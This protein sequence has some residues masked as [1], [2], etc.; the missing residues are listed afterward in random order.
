MARVRSMVRLVTRSV[1]SASAARR[2]VTSSRRSVACWLVALCAAWAC[3]ATSRRALFDR[4][5]RGGNFE[6]RGLLASGISRL[7]CSSSASAASAAARRCRDRSRGGGTILGSS[8]ARSATDA[9]PSVSPIF[10]SASRRVLN[11]CNSCIQVAGS[12]DMCGHRCQ[13]RRQ[14]VGSG[15][16][17]GCGLL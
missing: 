13:L 11:L 4:S 10:R 2:E 14:R 1:C 16:E 3:A 5:V 6:C 12:P 17:A 9:R 8:D 7:C 15:Q